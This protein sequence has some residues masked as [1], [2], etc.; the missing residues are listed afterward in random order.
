MS[1]ERRYTIVTGEDFVAPPEFR[2][3]AS[4]N[5]FDLGVTKGTG[6]TEEEAVVDL[7]LSYDFPAIKEGEDV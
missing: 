1:K 7:I 3:Q 4:W 6:R 5:D 2:W